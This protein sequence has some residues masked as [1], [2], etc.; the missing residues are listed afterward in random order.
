MQFGLCLPN[1]PFGVPP[2]AD[3]IVEIAQAADRT[4]FDSIWVTDHI[5]VPSDKPR[6]GVL[7]EVLATLAYVGAKTERVKLGTSVL[8]AAQRDALLVAKQAATIDDLTGGRVIIGVG[9]GWIEAEFKM[10]NADFPRRGKRLDE[11]IQAMRA[12]WTEDDP[13]YAGKFYNFSDVLFKPQPAQRGG[14]PI[15][16]GGNS[17]YAL[18][19]AANLG[20]GTH[21]DDLS[22]A[23]I[24]EACEKLQALNPERAK[25]LTISVRRTVDLRPA[26]AQLAGKTAPEAIPSA[27]AGSLAEFKA[28][29]AA[30]A[31]A[32]L[33]HFICQF[34][35]STQA[36]HLA[37]IELFEREINGR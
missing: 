16:V 26:L 17:D 6:Y 25:S 10:L 32:G 31:D 23:Q 28:E 37:Q 19:R 11:S 8:I 34:E 22:P 5:L 20:D 14:I 27:M 3:A 35:H 7:Y 30:Y 18:R 24:R 21:F 1:F 15:W 36:D 12:L 2:S 4:G 33:D 13:A 29:L 9:V